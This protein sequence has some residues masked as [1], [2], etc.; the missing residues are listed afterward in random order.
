[1]A[2]GEF[3]TEDA[4][5]TESEGGE[6]LGMSLS[7]SVGGADANATSDASPLSAG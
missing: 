5:D 6:E 7:G 4:E 2:E 3:T 1:M